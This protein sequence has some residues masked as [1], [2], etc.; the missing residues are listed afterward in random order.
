MEEAVKANGTSENKSCSY[1]MVPSLTVIVNRWDPKSRR[2]MSM[3]VAMSIPG[4]L[5]LLI[6]Y[7]LV[8]LLI[9]K[10]ITRLEQDEQNT[11]IFLELAEC[12]AICKS[13][14]HIMKYGWS[15]IWREISNQME[16]WCRLHCLPSAEKWQ[17]HTLKLNSTDEK[18]NNYWLRSR[19]LT[20]GSMLTKIDPSFCTD[21]NQPSSVMPQLLHVFRKRMWLHLRKH[22]CPSLILLMQNDIT[23]CNAETPAGIPTLNGFA[24]FIDINLG[25]HVRELVSQKKFKEALNLFYI[26]DSPLW[27]MLP[28]IDALNMNDEVGKSLETYLNRMS[29]DREEAKC[30]MEHLSIPDS[31]LFA[32]NLWPEDL[33]TYFGGTAFLTF[34]QDVYSP[35]PIKYC[36]LRDSGIRL[37]AEITLPIRQLVEEDSMGDWMPYKNGVYYAMNITTDMMLE[38]IKPT[39]LGTLDIASRTGQLTA[40]HILSQHH[41][42]VFSEILL[43]QEGDTYRCQLFDTPFFQ[44]SIY[45]FDFLNHIMCDGNL[46]R[47]VPINHSAWVDSAIGIDWGRTTQLND[48][49]ELADIIANEYKPTGKRKQWSPN[50]YIDLFT[51]SDR[52]DEYYKNIMMSPCMEFDIEVLMSTALKWSRHEFPTQLTPI[53][54]ESSIKPS[55]TPLRSSFVLCPKPRSSSGPISQCFTPSSVSSD[56][57]RIL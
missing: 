39:R 30:H 41:F 53:A 38:T 43:T 8:G 21:P 57:V 2:R 14:Y 17:I 36:L 40:S 45:V 32:E 35:P 51:E 3:A 25:R 24:T 5:V 20:V 16:E 13:F 29:L 52:G 27:H 47:V 55:T 56:V 10:G 7:A 26:T 48:T 50:F 23:L 6:L 54:T 19:P 18:K 46:K 22:C 31:S 42:K 15:S 12:R 28:E 11:D 9:E 44:H 4:Q 49:I 1:V 33:K 34:L 37:I